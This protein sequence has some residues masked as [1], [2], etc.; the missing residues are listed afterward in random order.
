M[1]TITRLY[2]V[3]SLMGGATHLV[4]ASS[5]AQAL[6]HVVR[7]MFDVTPAAALDVASLMGG[8][9]VPQV[10]GVTVEDELE[11]A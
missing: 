1:K 9:V 5:Q 7:G 2:V 4:Q 11:V 3:R 8:G 10:A 6:R